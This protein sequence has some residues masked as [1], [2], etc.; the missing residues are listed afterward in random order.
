MGRSR[1]AARM[2]SFLRTWI[3]CLLVA[4]APGFAQSAS[5]QR[6][7]DAAA[8]LY[9]NL[10]NERALDQLKTAR[11]ASGGVDDDVSIALYEGLILS[12]MGKKEE[13]VAAFREGLYLKPEAVLPVKVAPKIA[14]LFNVTKA[15]VL[16]G[17]APILAKRKA[18][19]EKKRLDAE[20]AEQARKATEAAQAE[21]LRV[22]A[23]R[24]ENLKRAAL[25]DAERKKL[26]LERAELDRKVA[27]FE[28]QKRLAQEEAKRRAVEAG[29][30]GQTDRPE[31]TDL[32]PGDDL[33]GKPALVA[34]PPRGV[35]V[36]PLVL[37]GL[38]VGAGAVAGVFGY[39]ASTEIAAAR[40]ANFQSQTV[41]HLNQANSD[42][43]V[44][45]IAFGAAGAVGIAALISIFVG[46][47]APPP[48][49]VPE[50]P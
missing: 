39:L 19:E 34:P 2:T 27:E 15:D 10:E 9:Q 5:A 48:A 46:R 13:A 43:L 33:R 6:Y 7:L 8:L 28:Q 36:A 30:L 42:A 14:E 11:A 18:E 17:L 12:D 38:A 37:G 1:L 26:E 3:V 35:P 21:K 20:K 23:E 40:A 22:E 45:N 25:S 49:A 29:R 50:T 16:K 24:L 47:E 32:T 4:S 31:R 41:Q 44:A